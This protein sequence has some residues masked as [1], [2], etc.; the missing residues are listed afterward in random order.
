[1]SIVGIFLAIKEW[2]PILGITDIITNNIFPFIT[3]G[4][5]KRIYDRYKPTPED[6]AF[7]LALKRWS[8]NYHLNGFYDKQLRWEK[9]NDFCNYV[10]NH[11]GSYDHE[12][13]CLYEF[14]KE[15]LEKTHEGKQFLQG[16][17]TK[18]LNKD[19]YE[20]LM[21]TN[22]ILDELKVLHG[23]QEAI[24]KELNS[25]NKGKR[26]FKPVEGYIN[27]SCSQRL[28]ND[29]VFTYLLEHKTFEKYKLVDVVS[30]RTICKGNKFI[31]YSDAQ[32]GKTTELLQLGWELQKE[33][34]L[35]PIMFKVKGCLNIKQELPALNKDFEKG[36]VIIIDALDEK[37]E[38]DAR[39][40]LYNEIET[41]AE[42]HPNLNMVLT[43]RENFCG[44]HSF[45]EFTELSLNDLTWQDSKDYLKNEGLAN[46][47]EEV[48]KKKLYEF[49]RTPFYLLALADYYKDKKCL[50]GN[51]GELYDFFIDRRLGQEEKLGLKQSAE[52][53]NRGKNLLG[54]M[55]LAMQIMGVSYITK[56]DILKL[57]DNNYDDF[58]RV[59][60]S[61]LIEDAEEKGYEFT[62]NS[63]K[64]Y[65]VSRYLLTL[66]TLDEI[67]K[68]C[69]YQFTKIVRTGWYNTVA[70]LLSQL[71]KESELSKEIL[72]WIV[73]DNKELVLYIDRNLF[74]EQQRSD[75]FKDIITW[76]KSKDLRI[77]DF[78]SSKYE[79]LMNFGR[80]ISMES[81]DY[82][83]EELKIC[84]EI[85]NHAVNLLFLLR[86]VRNEDL[87]QQKATELKSLLLK[88]FEKFKDDDDHIYVFFEV[89]RNPWLKTENNADA[90]YGFLK[91]SENPNIV[92]HLI[93]FFTDT[94]C[95][96]KYID[97]IINKSQFIHDYNKN[98]FIHIVSK[99]NLFDAYH[100]LSTWE[101]VKKALTQLI[102]DCKDHLYGTIDEEKYDELINKMLNKVSTMANEHPDVPNFV[103]EMLLNLAEERSRRKCIEKDGFKL[104]FE[105]TGLTQHY[106]NHSM[107]TL[108]GFFI[109]NTIS[110]FE[111]CKIEGNAYCA[112]I[113]LDKKRLEQ[114]KDM[115]DF[116]EPNG[117]GLLLCLSQYASEEMQ[118]E[119]ETIR[120]KYYPQYWTDKNAPTKW[121]IMAQR[122]YNELMDYDKFKGKVLEILNEKAP[123][124]K[125]DLKQLRQANVKF[126]E[127]EV[128]NISTYVMLLFNQ[129]Y[130]E[131]DDI[132]N[133]TDIR[134]Y[135]ENYS[136]Y[137]KLVV[138]NTAEILY[139]GTKRIKISNEQK[140][141]FRD[142]AENWLKELADAP[143]VNEYPCNNPAISVLLHHDVSVDD[144][145]LLRLL[146]Y[147]NCYIYHKSEGLYISEEYNLFDYICERFADKQPELLKAL[148]ACM[149]Q[150]IKYNDQNWKAWGIYLIKKGVSSEYER[151]INLMISLPYEDSSLSIAKEML[152]KEETRKLLL[153]DDVMKRCGAEKR[154]FIFKELAADATMDEYV[155]EGVE[156][157]FPT[158]DEEFKGEAVRLLLLKGSMMG[159]EYVEKNIDLLNMGTNLS[160]YTV[161]ALPMLMKIYTQNIDRLHSTV[162][163]CILNAVGE[164]ALTTDKGWEKVNVLFSELIEKYNQKYIHL[165]W[166]LRDWSVKRM[167]KAS[168]VM[169]IDEAKRLIN[170]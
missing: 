3:R 4:F 113:L 137:Q 126:S 169:T 100:S 110:N 101:S 118:K 152:V 148:R 60:R 127:E 15:E 53:A 12:I 82:L 168:P 153:N 84:N 132:Y 105:H 8:S 104:F 54:T 51:K 159:L 13:D 41:Y 165:N 157:D 117:H 162:K 50:P 150:P 34:K 22:D 129:F 56:N 20:N 146:P 79:D 123:Q 77:A 14:F 91:D 122:D 30:G 1:M 87:T 72:A 166:Y 94:G 99:E 130:N 26:E 138:I 156:K 147:S 11:H 25:H 33:G 140:R 136:V 62:H 37:F 32:T 24:W 40:S 17:R 55:A 5:L 160:N 170:N 92:N 141:L 121:E 49:V 133:L 39:F 128:F 36:I 142:S 66:D 106:F 131:S 86:H 58:N 63:F 154:L 42:E 161:A 68:L 109:N 46:I 38:G 47:V 52:M 28:K 71:P 163:S 10:I 139:N 89:F 65:F 108:K 144:E 57:F 19:L 43:C 112:A 7:K 115:I 67:Q 80:T 88:V 44:E 120:K 97:V 164:I 90:I 116:S 158:M 78:V 69:C 95:T 76:H 167:E 151:V 64:E 149:D 35:I 96:D 98:G 111:D 93:E 145:L 29:E 70:L 31:L 9:I 59:L 155:R 21:R 6:K 135:I 81:I 114:I 61:G 107:E 23:M 125:E 2:G 73:N 124:N 27:R 16:L 48:E 75:I 103:Y 119:I 74:D 45:E 18:S 83:M 102:K 143:H 134:D 85:E